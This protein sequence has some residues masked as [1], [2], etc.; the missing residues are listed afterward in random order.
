[1]CWESAGA[2]SCAPRAP[3]RPPRPQGPA[4]VEGRY[5]TAFPLKHQQKDMR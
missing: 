2:D 5:P 3:P 4:M 1:M